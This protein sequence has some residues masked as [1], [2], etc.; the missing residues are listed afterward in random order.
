MAIELKYL[1]S[2]ALL[3]IFLASCASDPSDNFSFDYS[4]AKISDFEGRWEGIIDCKYQGG[5]FKQQ[6]QVD[7]KN[8]MGALAHYGNR[9]RHVNAEFNPQNGK[10]KW[11]G[12][13]TR[14]GNL[15]SQKF[16][17]KGQWMGSKFYLKGRRG[18]ASC[19]GILLASG[20]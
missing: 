20:Q 14:P 9:G 6:A 19:S 17:V 10:I 16:S 1:A 12:E 15:S 2:T 18:I 4:S 11:Q 3:A 8:G 5:N 13:F 7:I